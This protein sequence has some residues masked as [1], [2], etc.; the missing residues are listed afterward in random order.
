MTSSSS[1]SSSSFSKSSS[2]T[3][4]S[5]FSTGN[6]N[7]KLR[8]NKKLVCKNARFPLDPTIKLKHVPENDIEEWALGLASKTVHQGANQC[9]SNAS[10]VEYYQVAHDAV[11]DYHHAVMK[12]K[13]DSSSLP[14]PAQV[15]LNDHNINDV[16]KAILLVDFLKINFAY[17]SDQNSFSFKIIVFIHLPIFLKSLLTNFVKC[18]L[19]L[20]IFLVFIF[21]IL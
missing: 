19:I 9:L 17:S 10:A 6:I 15:R 7:I 14:A 13:Q 5:T 3:S 21:K 18:R 4:I 11:K 8:Y 16:N 1:T 12:H 2:S 20:Y